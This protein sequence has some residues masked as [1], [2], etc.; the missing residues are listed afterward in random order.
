MSI[1]FFAAVVLAGVGVIAQSE[2]HDSSKSI[3]AHKTLDCAQCHQVVASIG[4]TSPGPSPIQQCRTCHSV[5]SLSHGELGKTFHANPERACSEC[6][7]FHHTTRVTAADRE[8]GFSAETGVALCAACHNSGGSVATLSPGHV[9]AARLYHSN[10]AILSGLNAS[11]ACLVCHSENRTTIVDGMK[12][13]N[14]PRFSERHTHP[15]GEIRATSRGADG[16]TIRTEF[17]PRLQLFNNRMECQTCHQLT[18]QTRH[19]LVRFETP[20]ALCNGC[21]NLH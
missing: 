6:H 5:S 4:S 8:F 18:A 13:S 14:M 16:S 20:Q 19:R 11:Q 17:D 15:V 10:S 3:S 9:E 2:D 21:H 12:L 1:G 7:S